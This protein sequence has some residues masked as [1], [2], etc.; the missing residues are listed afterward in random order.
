VIILDAGTATLELCR[1]RG[2]G[3]VPG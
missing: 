1:S 3:L 2:P